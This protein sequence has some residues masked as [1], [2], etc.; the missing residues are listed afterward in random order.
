[1]VETKQWLHR[2]PLLWRG[3]FLRRRRL[4]G[5]G[6][7]AAETDRIR[8]GAIAARNR[9]RSRRQVHARRATMSRQQLLL[10][11]RDA[12]GNVRDL[13]RDARFEVAPG[14]NCDR[15]RQ[16]ASCD[17]FATAPRRSPPSIPPACRQRQPSLSK[18]PN[19][20][21]RSTFRLR[22]CRSSPSSAAT[23]AAATAR[24]ADRTVSRCRCSASSRAKTTN[25]SCRKRAVGGCRW[26]RRNRACCC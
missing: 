10:D 22:W 8:A 3:V 25:T 11:G 23:A 19:A 15:R 17:P 18:T 2:C 21:C 16:P 4:G 26:R 24:A 13:T 20:I 5:P 7:L 12:A 6:S 9:P 14:R 1:M